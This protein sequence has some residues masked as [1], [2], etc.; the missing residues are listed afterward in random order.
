[1]KPALPQAG[2][3]TPG[4]APGRVRRVL[5]ALLYRWLDDVMAARYCRRLCALFTRQRELHAGISGKALYVQVVQS[6]LGTGVARAEEIVSLAAESYA[7][8][9]EARPVTFRD[10]VHYL[11]A[12]R[13]ME[14][15]G[16]VEGEIAGVVNT[17]VPSQW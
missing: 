12:S 9:P 1:M 3:T 17:H 2:P 11:V 7:I 5:C 6:H 13:L 15:Q 16:R 8:W 10:V 14:S 4:Q